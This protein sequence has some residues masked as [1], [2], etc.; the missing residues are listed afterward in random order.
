V[1]VQ[2]EKQRIV[3]ELDDRC[4]W[5]TTFQT[6]QMWTLALILPEIGAFVTYQD[7]PHVILSTQTYQEDYT[8]VVTFATISEITGKGDDAGKPSITVRADELALI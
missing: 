5:D 2:D 8:G 1:Y 6:S 7:K 4:K 3:G